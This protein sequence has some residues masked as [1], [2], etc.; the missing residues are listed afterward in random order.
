MSSPSANET[1]II[2]T[3]DAV[4][5]KKAHAG[6]GNLTPLEKLIYRVWV[7]DYGMRNAGDLATAAD[8]YANF[9]TEAAVL[10][11]D[12]SLKATREAFELPM[13]DLQSQ[14][15]KRFDNICDEI[16]YAQSLTYPSISIPN[17]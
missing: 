4:I 14:Y 5:H 11:N 10:A 15:F 1:W 6:V 12:L 16:R 17:P 3:G 9:Q 7:A 2:E 8:L 13:A